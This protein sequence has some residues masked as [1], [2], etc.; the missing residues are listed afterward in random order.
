MN[1]LKKIGALLLALALV[2]SL[3]VPAFADDDPVTLTGGKAG[4]TESTLARKL[5][6]QKELTVFNPTAAKVYAPN[7]E[8]TYA[9]AAGPAGALIDDN[10]TATG[11]LALT[12]SGPLPTIPTD[13]I[14]WESAEEVDA[15]AAG[16]ANA[17]SFTIDFSAVNFPGAGVYRYT[18]TESAVY[19]G[20]GVT[21]SGSHTRYLDVYVK[22]SNVIY[23]YVLS[24]VG[25]D[26]DGAAESDA[27]KTVG[28]VN[29]NGNAADRYYTTN[30]TVSKTLVGDSAKNNNPFPFHVNVT[31]AAVT[32]AQIKTAKSGTATVTAT[33]L[34]DAALN[35]QKDESVTIANGGSV[36]FIGI[37]AGTT[38]EV[39]EQNNVA[40]TTYTSS[41]SVDGAAA[42]GEKNIYKDEWSETA[43][44]TTADEETSAHTI[45]FTNTLA[46]IS[47]TGVVLRV[48]PY[49]LMLAAGIVLLVLSR[50]RRASEEA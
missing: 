24:T 14:K 9:I 19:A 42:A 31:A 26:I 33:S 6:I 41:Y 20:T 1:R 40:G 13:K 2:L 50:K 44:V 12:N 35:G 48:A 23:G 8:Y 43:S 32:K 5:S 34:G 30:L 27:Q 15:S 22:D 11:I 39:K 10:T 7:I 49:A 37:P 36:S 21:D 29:A 28:F 46:L 38:I 17:K 16:A 3:A 25:G 45:A 18:L 4:S 47:P